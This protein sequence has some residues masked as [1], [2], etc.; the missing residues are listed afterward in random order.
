M[1]STAIKSTKHGGSVTCCGNI[2]S[3]ELSTSIYPFILRGISLL[4]VDSVHCDMSIRLDIWD[5]LSSSWKPNNLNENVDE[6]SLERLN[7]KIDMILEGKHK[8]RT[9]VNLD[10]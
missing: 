1:L 4:G 9:I 5:K 8:G 2:A 3:H 6:V 7:N 10:L